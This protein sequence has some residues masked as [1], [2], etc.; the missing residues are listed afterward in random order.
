MVL[1]HQSF[2]LVLAIDSEDI[3]EVAMSPTDSLAHDVT[4]T[5][6]V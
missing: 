1:K 2:N 6:F 4:N 3:A 5:L